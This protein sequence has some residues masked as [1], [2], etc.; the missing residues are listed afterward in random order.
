MFIRLFYLLDIY[1][2][3]IWE[4]SVRLHYWL[5][6]LEKLANM[7]LSLLFSEQ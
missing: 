7:I 4:E 1:Q 3:L 6:E 5:H 2:T